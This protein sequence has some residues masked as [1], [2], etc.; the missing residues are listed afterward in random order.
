L[1]DGTRLAELPGTH[2]GA[3]DV[4]TSRDSRFAFVTLEGIGDEPGTI[5]IFDLKTWRTVAT[6]KVGKQVGGIALLP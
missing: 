2:A 4:V 5:D 6:V 3:S 1:P